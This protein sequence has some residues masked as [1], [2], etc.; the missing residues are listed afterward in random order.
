MEKTFDISSISFNAIDVP[1]KET[2]ILFE[3]E[4]AWS[5]S[6]PSS[7]FMPYPFISNQYSTPDCTAHSQ[8]GVSNQNNGLEAFNLNLPPEHR[9]IDPVELWKFWHK[10]G[11]INSEGWLIN[12]AFKYLINWEYIVWYSVVTKN[13]EP[14]KRAILR[15]GAIVTWSNKITWSEFDNGWIAKY[16]ANSPWHAFRI[17]WWDDSKWAF[18]IVNSWWEGWWDGW[19]FWLKYSDVNLLFTCYAFH[20]KKDESVMLR[21]KAKKNWIWWG[22][23]AEE[24]ATRRECVI[25]ASRIVWKRWTDFDLLSTAKLQWIYD[26]TRDDEPVTL[27]EAKVIFSRLWA[28]KTP[29][30]NT[31]WALSEC[32][33]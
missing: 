19:F 26:G 8:W 5:N 11:K 22:E 12:W 4:F 24:I 3:E 9:L 25:I 32:V 27:F 2:D 1:Q 15:N 20:D 14:I 28:K 30:S 18:R 10:V 16:R 6:L 33:Q 29:K 7:Y 21:A 17:D 13:V 23:R 31:R